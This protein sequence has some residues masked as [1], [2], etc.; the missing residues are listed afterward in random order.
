MKSWICKCGVKNDYGSP[1]CFVCGAESTVVEKVIKPIKKLSPEQASIKAQ[2]ERAYAEKARITDCQTA[3]SGCEQSE[4]DDH[5]HTIS[6][7]RCKDIGKPELITNVDNFEYS[8]RQ[9]HMEWESYK[10]GE[11]RKHKNFQKRMD[12]MKDHDYQGYV[13]RMEVV[14]LFNKPQET[15]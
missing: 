12:F 2:L 8:C 13:K 10:S 4:W 11:F 14:E 15:V 5:D 7:K 6:Q 3:C 9:C 1:L